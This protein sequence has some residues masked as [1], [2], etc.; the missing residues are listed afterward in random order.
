MLLVFYFV[1]DTLRPVFKALGSLLSSF[2][3]YPVK[4]DAPLHIEQ[5]TRHADTAQSAAHD[6]NPTSGKTDKVFLSGW[7]LS[8]DNFD[9]ARRC[10]ADATES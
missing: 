3:A 2:R 5:T 6:P 1:N 7:S 9:A 10:C 4:T 8:K